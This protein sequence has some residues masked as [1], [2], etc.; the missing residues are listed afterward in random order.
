MEQIKRTKFDEGLILLAEQ[1]EELY[2]LTKESFLEVKLALTDHDAERAL[3]VIRKDEAINNLEESI[4]EEAI[5]LIAKQAP[6]ATDLRRIMAAVKIANDVE[7]IADYAVFMA[8]YVAKSQIPLDG[9]LPMVTEQIDYMLEMFDKISDA[10]R[11]NDIKIAKEAAE[12]DSKLDEMYRANLK[13]LMKESKTRTDDE[14]LAAVQA[15]LIVKQIE[16]AGD[17][18]TNIAENIIYLVKGKRYDLN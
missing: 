7:R 3:R 9:Y 15:I 2:E 17:H 13:K 8:K 6:V 16:R 18:I 4:N 14:A 10:V 1:F 11:S 12:M 5:I